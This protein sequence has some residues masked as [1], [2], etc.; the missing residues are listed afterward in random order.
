MSARTDAR[1]VIRTHILNAVADLGG[2]AQGEPVKSWIL[3]K[4][5]AKVEDFGR[6]NPNKKY[7]NGRFVFVEAYTHIQRE[8][9]KKGNLFTPAWGWVSL[10]DGETVE[11]D[12]KALPKPKKTAESTRKVKSEATKSVQTPTETLSVPN[13][14]VK[15]EKEVDSE[16]AE[17]QVARVEAENLDTNSLS[18][19]EYVL[20][21]P[22][23]EEET[24]IEGSEVEPTVLE[25]VFALKEDHDVEVNNQAV[26]E[27]WVDVANQEL[28]EY[29]GGS[30]LY[31]KRLDELEDGYILSID[32][33]HEEEIVLEEVVQTEEVQE[34]FE[35]QPFGIEVEAEIDPNL[36]IRIGHDKLGREWTRPVEALPEE[37]NTPIT[38]ETNEVEEGDYEDEEES[39]SLK[40]QEYTLSNDENDE[41]EEVEEI[42]ETQGSQEYVLD[43]TNDL[44]DDDFFDEEEDEEEEDEGLKLLLEKITFHDN[45]VWGEIKDGI[46]YLAEEEDP[47][48]VL[49]FEMHTEDNVEG[50]LDSKR[51]LHTNKLRV[52]ASKGLPAYVEA[53]IKVKDNFKRLS[54]EGRQ[55]FETH[56][57]EE[58]HGCFGNAKTDKSVCR[59]I[60]PLSMLC[61]SVQV[62]NV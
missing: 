26:R 48:S 54:S 55:G 47:T 23:Q 21:E 11:V 30:K 18:A 12:G 31:R 37:Y 24:I 33:V 14:F 10:T 9:K 29:V 45:T 58:F 35:V 59:K 51:A 61:S 2:K 52:I 28:V 40:S 3:N 50:K 53:M 15:E 46:V 39:V 22:T 6:T 56:A 57:Q 41:V 8:E 7:P 62:V 17:V 34:P 32:D 44:F 42:L 13:G 60:C 1:Q 27:A 43:S 5:G 20:G 36:E 25:K 38:K 19:E 16:V 49:K 4:V